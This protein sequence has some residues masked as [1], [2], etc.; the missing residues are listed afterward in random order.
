M[1]FTSSRVLETPSS[2][3][4]LCSY[5]P[6]SMLILNIQRSGKK[7]KR[8]NHLRMKVGYKYTMRTYTTA[9]KK[10]LQPP[11]AYNHVYDRILIWSKISKRLGCLSL[12]IANFLHN[13]NDQVTTSH[14]MKPLR[15]DNFPWNHQ[16][17]YRLS[18]RVCTWYE[19]FTHQATPSS[20]MS[21]A[22]R[23]WQ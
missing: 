23:S 6:L 16:G 18:K 19:L 2:S 21:N 20:T 15:F 14:I 1:I 12:K 8:E 4:S 9:R 11:I 7:N 10:S 13:F 5:S 22:C 17:L 3:C